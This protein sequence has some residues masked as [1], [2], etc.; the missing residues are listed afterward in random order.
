MLPA[1]FLGGFVAVW[2]AAMGL[3]TGYRL[4]VGRINLS[5][6]LTVDGQRFSPARVQLLVTTVSGLAA[7]ATASLSAHAMVPVQ[8]ELVAIFGLSHASYLGPKAYRA[9]FSNSK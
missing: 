5:G 2:L 7:Y 3:L 6:L 4:L 8:N 1:D 9:M